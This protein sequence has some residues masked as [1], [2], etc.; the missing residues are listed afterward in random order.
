MF[1]YWCYVSFMG[2]GR[3]VTLFC[4]FVMLGVEPRFL[5]MLHRQSTI[6]LY[7]L[8]SYAAFIAKAFTQWIKKVESTFSKEHLLKN[9][10][11]EEQNL[12]HAI[13]RALSNKSHS[14]GLLSTTMCFCHGCLSLLTYIPMSPQ[15]VNVTSEVHEQL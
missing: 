15:S 8:R 14:C 3:T 13:R 11:P 6:E 7:I 1:L 12:H 10:C 4:Y 5:L 9:I 2:F